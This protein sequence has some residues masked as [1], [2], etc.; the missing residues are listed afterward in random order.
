MSVA[1]DVFNKSARFAHK[2][3]MMWAI[4]NFVVIVAMSEIV[5]MNDSR[6][7]EVVDHSVDGC[8]VSAR[9]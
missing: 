4:C 6:L 3:M 9:N 5:A 1:V 8:W 7:N 2:M